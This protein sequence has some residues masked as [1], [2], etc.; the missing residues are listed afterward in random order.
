MSR[1]LRVIAGA[2][3]VALVLVPRV[4]AEEA[5][6]E[7]QAAAAAPEKGPPLPFHTI[8]GYGGGAI[9]PMA[10]LVNPGSDCCVFG[11]PAAAM[12]YVNL[13][14]K[15]LDALTVSET[16]F[17]RVELSYGADRLGLGDLP[18]D[19]ETATTVDIDRTDVWL[20]NF[21]V[22]A[23]LIK[24]NDT[25]AD[26]PLPAVTA[27]I[28]FKYNNSIATINKQLDAAVAGGLG[29]IGYARSNGEDFTF[30]ATKTFPK[31]L[32]R[33][34]ITTAGLRLSQ[35]ANLGFLGFGD[36]Y[37]ATFEGN[38]AFLPL[39]NVL[40]AYEFRQKTDP[41]TLALAPVVGDEDNWQAIDV[42]LILN[43]NSTLVAGYGHFGTLANS[44]ANGAWFFQLKYEF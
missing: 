43:K 22:R 42:A 2:A 23:L 40:I 16:L 38:I 26:I 18:K 4:W 41:Y 20:H 44:E 3:V 8:E 36:K 37:H 10:Y 11:K 17:G 27:G 9:T 24:E 13:G 29:S 12:S 30:T 7:A 28:H 1:F 5:V 19:I 25:I 14:R 32:G 39:D 31:L 35:A 6:E 34:L 21:N 15:N 33:P